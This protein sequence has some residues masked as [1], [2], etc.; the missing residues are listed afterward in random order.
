MRRNKSIFNIIILLLS[1]CAFGA[2][3]AEGSAIRVPTREGVT[4]TLFWEP[5][6]NAAATVLLFPGGG[7][8]FGK[9]E[10]GQAMGQNFLVR[11]SRFFL[12]QG[13][14]VAIFGRPRDS[15]DLDY[16][17]RI[18]TAHLADV[19]KVIEAV[20]SK[21]S[22]PLWVVG[23]SRGTVSATATAIA[24]QGG[25]AGVVLTS[26]DP[27][28]RDQRRHQEA[29]HGGRRREPLRQPL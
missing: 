15:E 27:E 20:R 4:T 28:R 7:G 22:A 5:A 25:I 16:A 14:N 1:F 2:A 6:D 29:D 26:R 23:T 13:F 3:H 12:A 18:T 10:N 11:S 21:S 17:D 24:M 8:G 9:V 19:R